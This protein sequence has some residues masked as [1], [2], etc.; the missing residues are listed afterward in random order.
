MSPTPGSR[1]R[2]NLVHSTAPRSADAESESDRGRRGLTRVDRQLKIGDPILISRTDESRHCVPL[3]GAQSA[4]PSRI[5]SLQASPVEERLLMPF[6]A[7]EK[8]AK[9]AQDVYPSRP[10]VHPRSRSHEPSPL[11][12]AVCHEDLALGLDSIASRQGTTDLEAEN[13]EFHTPLESLLEEELYVAHATSLRTPVRLAEVVSAADRSATQAVEACL[14]KPLPDIPVN[15]EVDHFKTLKPHALSVNADRPQ[16]LRSH[17]SAWS[18]DTAAPSPPLTYIIDDHTSPSL[19]SATDI[20]S[21]PLSPCH[22]SPQFD[23]P[24]NSELDEQISTIE[25]STQTNAHLS[26]RSRNEPEDPSFHDL[27]ITPAESTG[28][29]AW[30]GS[31]GFPGYSLPEEGHASELTLRKVP[32]PRFSAPLPEPAIGSQNGADRVQSWNDGSEHRLT[33]MEELLND[34]GYL[35]GMIMPN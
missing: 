7:A 30:F 20:S 24:A 23:T 16:L 17:F 2:A 32:T 3:R 19:S 6:L 15:P 18:T 12:N 28:Q 31:S 25:Y 4:P 21:D 33:A 10:Q 5:S 11:R 26:N 1:R 22:L 13:I 35:G 8:P 34:L 29:A 14:K 27:R 9:C